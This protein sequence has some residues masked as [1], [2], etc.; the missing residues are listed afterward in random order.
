MTP[1]FHILFFIQ[2]KNLILQDYL[3]TFQGNLGRISRQCNDFSHFQK[4]VNCLQ[5][6]A[7]FM[8]G[9]EICKS[10]VSVDKIGVCKI[11]F[12]GAAWFM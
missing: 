5:I 4:S 2:G 11:G 8:F 6:L 10:F 7:R 3:D 12:R 1:F 9:L